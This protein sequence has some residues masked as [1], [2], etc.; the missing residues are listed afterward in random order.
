MYGEPEGLILIEP[1][2]E[3]KSNNEVNTLSVADFWKIQC[4]PSKYPTKDIDPALM[5]K[6]V[7]FR[8]GA[9]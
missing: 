4:K 5:L 1:F 3:L 9:F 7:M 8:E 6:E 2:D